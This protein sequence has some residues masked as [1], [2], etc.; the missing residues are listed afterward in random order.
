MEFKDL[1]EV[2]FLTVKTDF[3][4]D[5][6]EGGNNICKNL[7]IIKSLGIDYE[8]VFKMILRAIEA[9]KGKLADGVIERMFLDMN[10]VYE[11]ND[12]K[13]NVNLNL[14]SNSR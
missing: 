5:I 1:N 8:T 11:V 7:E 9:L 10:N 2:N 12:E 13:V 3:I 4:L 6:R 14:N